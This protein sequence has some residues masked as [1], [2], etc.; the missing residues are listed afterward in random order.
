MDI[1]EKMKLFYD[2]PVIS[3]HE[4]VGA[5]PGQPDKLNTEDCDRQMK[6]VDMLGV[7]K[8]ATSLPIVSDKHCPPEKFI[9]ANNVVYQ[10][11]QRHPGRIYGQAFVNPGFSKESIS[12]LER[13]VKELGFVAV[14]LYHQYFMD[15]PVMFPLIE[16]CIELDVPI[17]M[18]C[19]KV[20]DAGTRARQPRLSNGV[21]MAN[22]AR[23]Y[24]EATFI[25]AHIGG[26]G[27]W[28]WAI[29]AIANTPNVFADIGGSVHDRPLIE[30][31]VRYLGADR[32]LFATDG[33]WSSGVSKILGADISDE[34]KK[35]ILSGRAFNKYLERAG[36]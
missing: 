17:L 11:T 12:E 21:H 9:R 35:T 3:W 36:K 28:Q 34:D 1:R 2:N 25:M 24:P 30:E 4:H 33:G 14:K 16:K 26:G 5:L 27:D 7:D 6:T 31:S 32:L 19:A 20:M 23:R 29:K 22:A 15:D 10:A 18:H 13:C 8:I